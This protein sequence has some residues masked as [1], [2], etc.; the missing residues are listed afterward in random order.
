[1]YFIR[2]SS[3]SVPPWALYMRLS[4]GDMSDCRIDWRISMTA[5]RYASYS[6]VE[7]SASSLD[8]VRTV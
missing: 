3:D 8:C 6:V 7:Q 2:T 4:I 5:A 1:M